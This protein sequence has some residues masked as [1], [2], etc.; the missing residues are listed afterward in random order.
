MEPSAASSILDLPEVQAR[1]SPISVEEYHT[2]DEYNCRGRRT[3]LIR[4]VALEKV[5]KP[6][7]QCALGSDLYRRFSECL[8]EGY[9]L[10]LYD[11]LTF[12]DSEPEPDLA[13]VAAPNGEKFSGAHPTTAELVVEIAPGSAALDRA[14][15][16]LYAEAGVKEYWIVLCAERAVQVYR[17]LRDGVYCETS[18]FG[19]GDKVRCASVPLAPFA[20]AEL[21]ADVV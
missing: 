15:A 10:R 14:N 3:E 8:P 7:L 4:G 6:P 18:T 9:V 19:S 13:V 11:P 17:V 2:F 5:P 21:F 16:S 20:V 12:R 1:I